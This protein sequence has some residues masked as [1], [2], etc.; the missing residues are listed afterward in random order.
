MDVW[1]AYTI[2]VADLDCNPGYFLKKSSPDFRTLLIG[3]PYQ[4]NIKN[5]LQSIKKLLRF[6]SWGK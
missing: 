5:G 2:V 3:E 4:E 1:G 6:E